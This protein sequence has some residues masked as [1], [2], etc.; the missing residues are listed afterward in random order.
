MIRDQYFNE[1]LNHTIYNNV[2]IVRQE[3]ETIIYIFAYLLLFKYI[4]PGIQGSERDLFHPPLKRR[5]LYKK[6][7]IV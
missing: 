4:S 1:I 3:L 6:K 7:N 5:I 2:S